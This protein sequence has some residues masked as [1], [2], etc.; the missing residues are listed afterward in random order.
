MFKFSK[1]LYGVETRSV[2]LNLFTPADQ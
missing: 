2:V 1:P